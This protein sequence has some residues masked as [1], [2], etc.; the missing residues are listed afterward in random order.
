[1]AKVKGVA[2]LGVIKFI[3]KNHKDVLS[4]VV[5]ALPP[6]SGKYMQEHLLVTEWYPYKIY[7]DLLRALDKV[8]GK[9]DLSTC[10]EQGRLSAKHDLSTVF[11]MF[12]NFSSV[13]SMLS[14]VMVAWTSYY[15][16]G[17]IEIPSLTDKEATYFIKDFPEI[18]MVHVKNVQG[19]MEQF[20]LI[21]LKAKD[22]KSEIVKCQCHGDPVTEMHFTF[23]A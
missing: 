23:N 3:K 17:K 8:I 2:L 13:Q 16:T 11:K 19:W 20:F 21:A 10:I 7:T 1:M 14:R 15:D 4:K 22:I 18:D 6:E 5:D 12:L 9:G